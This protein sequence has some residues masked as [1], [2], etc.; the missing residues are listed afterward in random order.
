MK[1]RVPWQPV[2]AVREYE[3][4]LLAGYPLAVLRQHG[5]AD[6]E[7]P[8]DAKGHMRQFLKSYRPTLHQLEATRALNLE[9]AQ[10]QSGSFRKLVRSIAR[11]AD[12]VNPTRG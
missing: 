4:W 6:P 1:A 7:S 10:R 12:V 5:I 2:M 8:R 9:T 11:L 3:S